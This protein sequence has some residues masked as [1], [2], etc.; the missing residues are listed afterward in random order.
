MFSKKK[1]AKSV[2][3]DLSYEAGMR[4]GAGLTIEAAAVLYHAVRWHQGDESV[5]ELRQA[6]ADYIE[7]IHQQKQQTKEKHS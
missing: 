3:C 4:D 1:I 6:V 5:V 2:Q 7:A